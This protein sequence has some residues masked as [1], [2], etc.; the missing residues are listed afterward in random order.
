MLS[1]ASRTLLAACGVTLLA[2]TGG[3]RHRDRVADCASER[4]D[5]RVDGRVL[6]E[7]RGDRRRRLRGRAGVQPGATGPGLRAHRHRRCLSL[8]RRREQ[9]GS[10]DGLHRLRRLERARGRVHRTRSGQPG[11]GV[12]GG[13][14]VHPAVGG[15]AGR[16]DP[17]LG[18][19][20][21]YLA[22]HRPADP[23]RIQPER[24]QHGRAARRRPRRRRR[25]VPGQPGQ[26][27]VAQ[28][29]RRRRLGAGHQLPGDQHP[30][31]YRAL[32]RHVRRGRRP[33]RRADQDDLRGQRDRHRPV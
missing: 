1:K 30:G 33:S 8:G 10:A 18:R 3:T 17:P 26:R 16:R 9:V 27:P 11:Q 19:P 14:R 5:G 20:G 24:P 2:G 23:A 7:Q 4:V 25:P 22:D 29:R 6:L 12:G 28:H 32:V 13:G 15:S 31:R 21:P